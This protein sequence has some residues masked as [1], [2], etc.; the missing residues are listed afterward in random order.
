LIEGLLPA[1][2]IEWRKYRGGF[3]FSD[4]QPGT[5]EPG[6]TS[7]TTCIMIIPTPV[8]SQ[9][10]TGRDEGISFFKFIGGKV[11]SAM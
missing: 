7:S 9:M 4:G 6:D 11:S 2:L 10:A 8:R 1:C 3:P 5:G